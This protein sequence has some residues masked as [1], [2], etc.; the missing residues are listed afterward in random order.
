MGLVIADMDADAR[1]DLVI[2]HLREEPNSL[3][4][5]RGELGFQDAT[6][7]SG[8]GPVSMPFTGFGVAALDFDRDTDLDLV[9]ANGAVFHRP[10]IAGAEL[11]APWI[12]YAETNLFHLNRGDGTFVEANALAGALTSR[13]EL[14]R[15]LAAGDVDGDFDPD[16]LLGKI[17]GR[18]SLFRNDA[19]REGRHGLALRCVHPGW[20]RDALGARVEVFAGGKRQVQLLSSS[21]SYCSS[22][23]PVAYF[24]LDTVSAVERIEVLWPDGVRERFPGPAVD[25]LHV[26]VRGTGGLIQ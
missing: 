3:F 18:A 7:A 9:I 6:G 12:D 23:P 20:K 25:G 15:G 13:A 8:L 14:A 2:T 17:E 10:R 11:S 16:L 24:G 19:P 1:L 5:N 21:W 22:S 26:L 4:L